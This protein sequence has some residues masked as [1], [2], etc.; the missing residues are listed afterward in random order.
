MTDPLDDLLQ[1]S[2]PPATRRSATLEQQLQALARSTAAPQHH[3]RPRR[4]R[5]VAVGASAAVLLGAGVSAAAAAPAAP[6]WLP[7]ADAP[8]A[9]VVV[10][11]PDGQTCDTRIKVHPD[12]SVAGGDA[13]PAAL[14]AREYLA[15]LDL[16]QLDTSAARQSMAE[17]HVSPQG[18][19]APEVI[20][21]EQLEALALAQTVGDL[22]REELTRQ[23]LPPAAV[24]LEGEAHCTEEPR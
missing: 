20:T 21:A 24:H 19:D 9:A 7:W 13:E 22:V 3:R 23:G 10:E 1:G 8:D 2:A 14:A 4:A 15:D 16:A 12:P 11:S 6:S 17:A 5:R 18:I